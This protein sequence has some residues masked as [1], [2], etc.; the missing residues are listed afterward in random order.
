M[1]VLITGFAGSAVAVSTAVQ[2]GLDV[3]FSPSYCLK[4]LVNHLVHGECGASQAQLTLR[5]PTGKGRYWVH[6]FG[7]VSLK[8]ESFRLMRARL[9]LRYVHV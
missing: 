2:C 8:L 7:V 1:I 4:L 3:I 9:E 6:G 5:H